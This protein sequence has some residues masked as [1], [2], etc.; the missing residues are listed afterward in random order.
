MGNKPSDLKN[1]RIDIRSKY[2]VAKTR[3]RDQHAYMRKRRRSQHS[4]KTYILEEQDEGR[5]G[6]IYASMGRH[7]R[8]P[9]RNHWLKKRS[10][11]KK[12]KQN[13]NI[14]D[15]FTEK[16]KVSGRYKYL[17]TSFSR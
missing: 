9:T 11:Y 6:G 10:L 2:A 5:L 15:F 12:W 1:K 17:E 8:R 16:N 13:K 14:Q 3:K 4:E 7:V